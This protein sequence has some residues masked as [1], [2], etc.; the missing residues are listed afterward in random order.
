[1]AELKRCFDAAG[2]TDVMTVLS[3]GNVVF[4]TR[5]VGIMTDLPLD[6]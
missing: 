4:S 5:S 1:M 2:F 6:R 3:S